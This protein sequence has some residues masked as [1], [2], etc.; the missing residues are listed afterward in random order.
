M[1]RD[2][3]PKVIIR[4]SGDRNAGKTACAMIITRALRAA[5]IECKL[6]SRWPQYLKEYEARIADPS[7]PL[8]EQIEHRDIQVIDA[9]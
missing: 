6:K 5:G 8:V 4:I 1:P 9:D 7:D 2:N 3:R